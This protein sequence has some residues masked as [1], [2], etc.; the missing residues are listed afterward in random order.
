MGLNI[1]KN[2]I[3]FLI[4]LSLALNPMLVNGQKKIYKGP[5]SIS[6]FSGQATYEYEVAGADTL[7]HGSFFMHQSDIDALFSPTGDASFDFTGSF[8]NNTAVGDWSFTFG[9]YQGVKDSRVYKNQYLVKVSGLTHIAEGTFVSGVPDGDWVYEVE[10]LDSSEVVLVRFKSEVKFDEGKPIESFV[11]Q[12]EDFALLGRFLDDG[13]AHDFWDL[14]SS[15]SAS[16]LERWFFVNGRLREIISYAEG[17]SDTLAVYRGEYKNERF[18]ALDERYLKMLSV[19][20]SFAGS[21][22]EP[23][24]GIQLLLSKHLQ[25]YQKINQVL[26]ELGEANFSPGIT[27]KVDHLPVTS[28]EER[29]LEEL[30]EIQEEISSVNK[31]VE[32]NTQ[33]QLLKLS[34][35]EIASL[36]NTIHAIRDDYMQPVKLLLQFHG[37]SVLSLLSRDCIL[38]KMTTIGEREFLKIGE[39]A[40]DTLQFF[41][42]EEAGN[43]SGGVDGFLAMA[44]RANA[45][46]DSVNE[47]LQHQ[48]VAQE[49]KQELE[50]L[51]KVLVAKADSLNRTV[52]AL[53]DSV[54]GVDMKSME[55]IKSTSK[56][57]I[58]SYTEMSDVSDKITHINKLIPCMDELTRLAY[59]LSYLPARNKELKEIYKDRVWNP[60]TATLM[61]EQVKKRITDAY[62]HVIIPY[63]IESA[64]KNLSCANAAF[65]SDLMESVYVRMLALRDEETRKLERKLKN[66]TRIEEVLL[67]IQVE[68]NPPN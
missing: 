7:L 4:L 40:D 59:Q 35:K 42:A 21:Q 41:S 52:D 36:V 65:L 9:N 34:N 30:A 53:I 12:N 10:E 24:D 56:N 20:R 5:L 48:L 3:R 57:D 6:G 17:Q 64:R 63:I 61:D 32:E 51:E 62:Q 19:K 11:M 54:A 15:E 66:E 16:L 22:S 25:G 67:L 55:N 49:R 18:Q 68:F 45:V 8:E 31:E 27:V 29:I 58:R 1:P 33:I 13:V 26:N 46:L 14:Y 60:F 37:D 28:E 47:V 43:M 23:P 39:G 50:M 38:N 2:S 44:R